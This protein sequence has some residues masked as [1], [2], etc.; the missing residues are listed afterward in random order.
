MFGGFALRANSLGHLEQID[1][2]A[3]GHQV[4]FRS[5]N[6]VVDIRGDSI[7]KGFETVAIAPPFSDE[8]DLNLSSEHTQEMDLV[9]A[10]VSV[11]NQTAP[12]EA[13]KS[14][15]LEPHTDLT[16]CNAC[17]NGTP[18]SF[19][20]ACSEPD[21]PADTELDRLSIFEFSTVDVFQ[22][23]PLGDVLNSLKNLSLEEDSQ[24]NNVRFELEADDEEFCFPP[25]TH[26]IAPSMT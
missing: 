3:P 5:L 23:S 11:P 12:S 24:P 8:H 20:A 22:H 26:F 13:I 19:R 1:S 15:A 21:T 16:S 18:D 4:R 14:A 17:V 9:A 6:Y 10:M 2:Y 25:A 7:F